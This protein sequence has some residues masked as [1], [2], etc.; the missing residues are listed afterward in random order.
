MPWKN[1]E[2]SRK[3]IRQHYQNNKAYYYAKNNRRRQEMRDYVR[4]IK[5]TTPC[6]DCGHIYPYYVMDF[7]HIRDKINIV[8]HF[9]KA[10][11]TKKLLEEIDKCEVVCANCHRIR[12]YNRIDNE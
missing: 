4:N 8:S 2:K 5:A 12:T 3:A 9:V 1:V 7:D 6:T 10:M 11:S